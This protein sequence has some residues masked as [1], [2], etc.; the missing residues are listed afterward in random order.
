MVPPRTERPDGPWIESA[1]RVHEDRTL[2]RVTAARTAMFA[3]ISLWLLLNYGPAVA[4]ENAWIMALFMAFG[5]AAYFLMHGR[6]DRLWLTYPFVVL[7]GLLLG[8]T[9]L[10]PGRTYPDDWPWQSV[11]RQPSFLYT[12]TI[13]ALAVLSFRPLLVVWA[14]IVIAAVWAAGTWIIATAPGAVVGMADLG[15]QAPDTAYLGR[16]FLPNYVHPDDAVVRIFVLLLLVAIL[17]YAAARARS[18]VFEQAEVARERANLAR[19]VAPSMVDRLAQSDNPLAAVRRQDAAVLFA[20]LR[21]FT[22]MAESLGPDGT[23]ALLREY[24]AR[25]ARCV[26]AHDGTLDKF[27][28]DG[29]MATFGT[30][31][32]APDDP[33]RALACAEGMLVAVADWNAVRRRS[34]LP[35]LAIGIGLHYGPVTMGDIGGERRFEFAVIGDTVNVANRLER[36]T[37]SLG[38]PLLVS[39]PALEAAIRAGADGAHF[40]SAG[41][42]VLRGRASPLQVWS[43]KSPKGAMAE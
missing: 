12:L 3:T 26:F 23:M 34:G 21:G 4:L 1:L 33:R 37:R 18:L 16:Y 35:P 11:L 36:L 38:S 19:Y 8:Y 28:G 17:A 27:I 7:D 31:E 43:W 39:G 2:T 14:G 15:P 30:S 9:L 25:M 10:S 32:T 22:A 29:L 40:A 24:H 20:D 41:E 6:P 42:R 13:P 5:L